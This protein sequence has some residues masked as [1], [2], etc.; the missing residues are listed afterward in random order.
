M[1]KF[2][3]NDLRET[4]RADLEA[5][6]RTINEELLRRRNEERNRLIAEFRKTYLALLDAGVTI[7]Y[8]DEYEY[9]C[10][11]TLTDWDCFTF[12]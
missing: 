4:S 12:D 5:T 9:E 10:D 7:R 11:T 6:V 2:S 8:T 3:V 1:I